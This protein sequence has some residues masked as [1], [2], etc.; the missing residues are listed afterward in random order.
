[1]PAY[2]NADRP[3]YEPPAAALALAGD[4]E[5][6]S[7]DAFPVHR[8]V[9]RYHLPLHVAELLCGLAGIGGGRR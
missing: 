2:H 1:M 5:S 6:K 9:D 4:F 7:L 8:I 3:V